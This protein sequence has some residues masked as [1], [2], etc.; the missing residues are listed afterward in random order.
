MFE[1][2]GTFRKTVSPRKAGVRPASTPE[3]DFKFLEDIANIYYPMARRL[4]EE[5][6]FERAEKLCEDSMNA[7]YERRAMIDA[8]AKK[9][10]LLCAHFLGL[11]LSL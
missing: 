11:G 6:E 4:L 8:R 1:E 7:L 9:N 5:K 3:E 2:W 10:R